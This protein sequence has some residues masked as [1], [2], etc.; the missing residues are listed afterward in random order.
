MA[1]VTS[2]KISE[3][4]NRYKSID[5]T[6]TKEIIQV[7]GLVTQ[8]VY[9]KC[10][11]D[12][13]PCVIYSCS[14]QG[15]KVVANIKSGI[16]EKLKQANS[17][18]QLRLCFKNSETGAL[19]S[20]FVSAHHQ[21]FSAYGGSQDMG[22]FN[23]QFPG[24]APDDL[25]EIF[26]RLLDA[27]VNSARRREERIVMTPDVVRRLNILSKECA[28]FIQGVPRHC[29]LRDIAFS[30]AK[31]IMM[32]VVKFLE[33]KDISLRV[34]FEDPR[35][36]FL[37]KGTFIRSEMVEGRKDLVALVVHFNESVIPMGFK[38]RINDYLSQTHLEIMPEATEVEAA[39]PA[40]VNGEE[41]KAGN[42]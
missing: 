10:V 35:E 14:F 18:V 32:G 23:L 1:I 26:G 16:I 19:V 31:L 30:G 42:P 29:I 21:G 5:V 15:A 20:F 34:E 3:Y 11:G 33:G 17:L 4:Y 25:I 12:F 13:W 39:A 36:S 28:V 41:G 22:L 40:A 27:N 2:Q 6:F 38:I 37:L 9:L 7:T 8:Q 24:R